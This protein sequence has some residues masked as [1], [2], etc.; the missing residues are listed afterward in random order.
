M[1]VAI[2]AAS[3]WEDGP[4]SVRSGVGHKG[5]SRLCVQHL[6]GPLD[7]QVIRVEENTAHRPLVAETEPV[8]GDDVVGTGHLRKPDATTGGELDIDAGSIKRRSRGQ[9]VVEVGDAVQR[10]KGQQLSPMPFISS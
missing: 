8:A 3:K 2:R 4:I 7:E 5:Y 9:R 6:A 1:S 10:G